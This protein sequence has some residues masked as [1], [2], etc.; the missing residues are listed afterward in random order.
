MYWE[1]SSMRHH[2]K[3]WLTLGVSVFRFGIALDDRFSWVTGEPGTVTRPP[4]PPP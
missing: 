2:G 3:A 1:W 4:P